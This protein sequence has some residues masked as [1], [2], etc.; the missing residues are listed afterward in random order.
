V[1]LVAEPPITRQCTK[2]GRIGQRGKPPK[3]RRHGYFVATPRGVEQ[4]T[5]HHS[6]GANTPNLVSVLLARL[7]LAWL[8]Q[9]GHVPFSTQL[10]GLR[11]FDHQVVG[12]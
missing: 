2:S 6:F 9:T 5:L 7:P 10:D 11:V 8:V 4:L 3:D 12:L 1:V